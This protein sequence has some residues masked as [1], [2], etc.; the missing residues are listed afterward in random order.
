VL[1]LTAIIMFVVVANAAITGILSYPNTQV[2]A[3]SLDYRTTVPTTE[4][5]IARLRK[6]D[7]V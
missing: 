4:Q 5:N 3:R 6:I 7:A 2:D 1:G